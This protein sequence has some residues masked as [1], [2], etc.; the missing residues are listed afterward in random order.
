MAQ[1]HKNFVDLEVKKL[2]ERYLKKEIER[3]YVQQ[4]LGIGKTRFFAIV[5]E[6]RKNPDNFSIQYS[7]KAKTRQ[8]SKQIEKNILKELA[9]EKKIIENKNMP[10]KSYNYSYIRNLL[11]EK[12][13]QKVSL[14]TIIDRAKKH[15]FYLKKPKKIHVHD[16]QVLTNYI[17]ELIQHD[18]SYHLWS[19]YAQ[20]KW[21]L[22]TSLDDFSRYILYAILLSKETS[23]DHILALESVF[24]NYGLPY[25]YYVDC[26]S[27]F[28]FVQGRDSLWPKHHKI[29]DETNP[30]GKQV[31]DDCNVK[32]TYALSPQAKGKAERPYGWLQG[33]LV[34]TCAREH[35][36]KIEDAQQVLNHEVCRYNQYLV[37]STTREVPYRRFQTALAEKQSLFREFSIKL[38]FQSTKDIFCLRYDRIADAYRKISFNNLELRVNGVNPRDKVNMRIYLMSNGLSEVRFWCRDKLVD[39]KKIKTKDLNLPSF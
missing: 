15:G 21:Y 28:R 17:G 1:L 24:L 7:R 27:I 36:S 3:N 30:Q 8:I 25:S 5:K 33:H 11:I 14:P 26:H 34:R 12:Y 6:Y 13:D 23:W 39:V 32:V 35:I 37:H 10:I 4:I 2:I 9:A 22:I 38:P 19:P 31:L 29:T 20:E 18:T 16:R